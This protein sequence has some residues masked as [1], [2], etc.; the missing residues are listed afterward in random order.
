[1]MMIVLCDS[2]SALNVVPRQDGW[3]WTGAL[4]IGQSTL[5][6]ISMCINLCV[7]YLSTKDTLPQSRPS[8]ELAATL[9]DISYTATRITHTHTHTHNPHRSNVHIHK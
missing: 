8:E 4:R 5:I 6:A 9:I 2:P 7:V 3:D 1:M